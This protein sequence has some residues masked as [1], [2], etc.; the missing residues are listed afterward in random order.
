MVV[1]SSPCGDMVNHIPDHA[2][3]DR[4]FVAESRAGASWG[5]MRTSS[6]FSNVDT[7]VA[8][9]IVTD[10]DGLAPVGFN[11]DGSDV[12]GNIVIAA[13]GKDTA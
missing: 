3:I 6:A 10:I 2:S 13:L 5:E 12:V 11:S 4:L 7:I 1:D 9:S 8:V